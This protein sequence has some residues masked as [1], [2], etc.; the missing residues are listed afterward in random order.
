M[1]LV[2]KVPVE[3]LDEERLTNIERKLVVHVSEMRQQ[4]VRAPWRALAFAGIGAVVA[5]A[6]FVGWK[7]HRDPALT[8]PA[9][10]QLAMKAGALDLGDARIRGNDFA[11]TRTATR[12]E[13]AM[14]PGKLELHV[15]HKPG[16]LFVVKAGDVEIEDVG[17][18][19]T[20]DYDGKNVDVSVSEGEVKVKHAGKEFAVKAGS[21]WDLELGPI[22]IAQLDAKHAE[23]VAQAQLP[24]PIDVVGAA[25]SGSGS[26]RTG[27]AVRSGNG[28]AGTGSNDVGQGSGKRHKAGG[29]DGKKALEKWADEPLVPSDEKDPRK[30]IQAYL[31]Q[32]KNMPEGE[33]KAELLQ[34]I[35]VMHLRA[36]NYE[37]ARSAVQGVLHER[38]HD[39]PWS[40]WKAYKSALWL[41]VRSKCLLARSRGPTFDDACRFAVEKFLHKFPSSAQSGAAQQVLN[42]I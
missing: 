1:K 27:S 22:T 31:E 32:V 15:D 2:G 41:D 16:R 24:D 25:G 10:E 6:F 8:A 33:Q 37:G 19:F 21:A 5:L 34:S 3:P 26:S 36:K 42:E 4:P 39:G 23:L 29:P 12:T 38:Q 28:S 14:K 17:T 11:V 20:V 18:R 30:A 9:P 13:I 40:E 7:L 35:A